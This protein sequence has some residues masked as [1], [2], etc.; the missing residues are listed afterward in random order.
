MQGGRAA[1]WGFLSLWGVVGGR[2]RVVV[3]LFLAHAHM[4]CALPLPL[5]LPTPQRHNA[6]RRKRPRPGDEGG[7][8]GGALEALASGALA[9]AYLPHAVQVWLPFFVFLC[10]CLRAALGR[11]SGAAADV[12]GTCWEGQQAL[13]AGRVQRAR[14]QRT[15]HP[16]LDELPAP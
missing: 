2:R 8:G 3:G 7:G 9:D 10:F 14:T 1:A 11:G 16:A 6:R 5:P 12:A 4:C 13:V 15:T